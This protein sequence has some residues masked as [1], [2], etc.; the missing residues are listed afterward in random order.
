MTPRAWAVVLLPGGLVVAYLIAQSVLY[1]VLSLASFGWI[2]VV[3]LA[4]WFGGFPL[5][6]WF[7]T[8]NDPPRF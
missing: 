4:V 8:R 2:G 1:D 7:L 5:A 3:V 6:V